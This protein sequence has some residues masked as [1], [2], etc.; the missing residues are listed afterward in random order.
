LLEIIPTSLPYILAKP[1]INVGPNYFLYSRNL[2]P[3]TILEIT[4]L[5]SIGF[6]RSGETI[7]F[8]SYYGYKGG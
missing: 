1:V 2:E 4:N 5:E 6:L 7:E 3:S 8:N